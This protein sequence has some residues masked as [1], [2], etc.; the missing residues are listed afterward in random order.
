MGAFQA[1]LEL[2]IA[3][4]SEIR[5]QDARYAL[6]SVCKNKIGRDVAWDWVRGN[7]EKIRTYFLPR[8]GIGGPIELMVVTIASDFNTDLQLHELEEFYEQH[9]AYF[10]K[11][12]REI[13]KA[14][15]NVKANIN[16][17][18]KNYDTIASWLENRH[19]SHPTSKLFD[20][21]NFVI[22]IR[23]ITFIF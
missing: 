22:A 13:M 11:E 17:R 2:V 6:M 15:Q 19:L 18:E 3:N 4:N 21:K 7:Y 23:Y 5:K 1:Y 12:N 8:S 20:Y 16:W 10:K 9:I 14:I